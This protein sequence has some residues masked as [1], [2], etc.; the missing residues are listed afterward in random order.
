MFIMIPLIQKDLDVFREL[1][2]NTHRIRAQKDTILTDGIPNH[3][4]SFPE[5]YGLEECGLFGTPTT[6]SDLAWFLLLVIFSLTF[7]FHFITGLPTTEEQLKEVATQS[8][9]LTVSDDFLQPKFRA[10]CG[11]VLPD[12]EM[13]RPHECRDAYICLKNNFQL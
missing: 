11:C 13:I 4:Y 5:Q 9:M 2:C 1:V 7:H 3:M 10:E 8:G 6:I 12:S